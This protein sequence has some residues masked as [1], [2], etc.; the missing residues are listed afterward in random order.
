MVISL[1]SVA[2]FL[3]MIQGSQLDSS[4]ELL[5]QISLTKNCQLTG[6][7]IELPLFVFLIPAGALPTT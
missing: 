5:L 2:F 6:Y 7:R 4:L 3:S 1:S